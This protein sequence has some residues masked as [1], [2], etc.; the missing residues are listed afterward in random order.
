MRSSTK[1]PGFT[2]KSRGPNLPDCLI[3][4]KEP[5]LGALICLGSQCAELDRSN[6]SNQLFADFLNFLI[7]EAVEEW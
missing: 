4:R 2:C 6:Q 5:T 1:W 3:A 7:P